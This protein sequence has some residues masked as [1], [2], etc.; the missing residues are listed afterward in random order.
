[1][2]SLASSR[3]TLPL[4]LAFLAT[5]ALGVLLVTIYNSQT[6]DLYP[7]NAHHS[8]GWIVTWVVSAHVTVSL[9]GRIA[10]VV[11]H[12]RRRNLP[13]ED[14]AFMAVP[15]DVPNEFQSQR[16]V[17]G[18]RLS[19]DSTTGSEYAGESLRSGSS[20]THVADDEDLAGRHKEEEEDEEDEEVLDDM[21]FTSLSLRGRCTNLA[22]KVLSVRLWR[23]FKIGYKVVDRVILPFGFIAFTTGIVTFGRFFVR[24]KYPMRWLKVDADRK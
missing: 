15:A 19:G 11:K 20:S 4:Q 1:M 10:C 21:P 9:A 23:F 13:T 6:P 14:H 22:S 2:L 5:N 24:Q 3:F 8:I 7:G 18:Y 12:Y 17:G 16:L